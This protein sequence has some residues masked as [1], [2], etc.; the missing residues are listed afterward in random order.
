MNQ[1]L[2]E[3]IYQKLLYKPKEVCNY[4][5]TKSAEIIRH[6]LGTLTSFSVQFGKTMN[7]EKALIFLLS[8]VPLNITNGDA[9]GRKTK[10]SKLKDVIIENTNLRTDKNMYELSRGT[11][12]IDITPVMNSLVVIPSS[13]T[14]EEPIRIFVEYLP[15]ELGRKEVTADSY[16]DFSLKLEEHEGRGGSSKIQIARLK[17]KVVSNFHVGILQHSCNKKRLLKL[18]YYF[19]NKM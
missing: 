12:I 11:A 7:Y 4:G 19:S 13:S 3:R 8:P 9:S 18:I 10:A 17:S 2:I 14:Y 1:F 6:I 16:K 5:K 15:K